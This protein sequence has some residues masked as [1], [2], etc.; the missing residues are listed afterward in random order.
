MTQPHHKVLHLSQTKLDIIGDIHGEIEAL[1][2]MLTLLGYEENGTHPDNRHLVFVGDLMDRG[3]NSWAVYTKVASMVKRGVAHCVLGNHE[4]NLLVP[5]GDDPTIPKVKGGNNWF[6]GAVELVI[7]D[8]PTSIQPQYL[9]TSDSERLEIQQ[10]CAALP[11]AIEAP[12]IRIV[13]ACW[14]TE[15]IEAIR[16]DKRPILTVYQEYE[17]QYKA[18]FKKEQ[19][20]Y[21]DLRG[22]SYKDAKRAI[23]PPSEDAANQTIEQ[24]NVHPL[25]IASND[26]E[27]NQNPIKRL[28]SG[29]ESP[30]SKFETPYRA[31]KKLRYF[32]RDPWWKSYE[33]SNIVVIGHY[34]RK[35]LPNKISKFEDLTPEE[36]RHIP[37]VF[38]NERELGTSHQMLGP[39]KNVMCVDYAVGKRFWERHHGKVAGSSGALLGALRYDFDRSSGVIQKSLF[40]NDGQHIIL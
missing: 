22:L 6:H 25:Y 13:H 1:N 20:K 4:L 38:P 12:G 10:F 34:W 19:D 23:K 24:L 28:T 32:K 7:P 30:L 5:A 14:H 18:W 17:E 37:P 15:S 2:E 40:L 26:K 8:D 27:Q 11:L 35:T 29:S 39:M 9:L 36:E 33:E 31:S 16:N 21:E 3:W